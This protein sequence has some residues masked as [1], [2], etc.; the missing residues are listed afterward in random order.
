MP[1]K[2]CVVGGCRHSN[3]DGS[4]HLFPKDPTV[5]AHAQEM[6]EFCK[7][8]ATS[9][10]ASH[11][12]QHHMWQSLQRYWLPKLEP[13]QNGSSVQTNAKTQRCAKYKIPSAATTTHAADGSW[14]ARSMSVTVRKAPVSRTLP[15][16]PAVMPILALPLPSGTFEDP[17]L[18]TN[19][20]H[21]ICSL[22]NCS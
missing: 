19:V 18:S 7:L 14:R 4:V 3:V 17:S 16:P 5:C 20:C 1:V 12:C 9:L 13:V 10:R 15:V 22:I 11:C 2:F 6:G 21:V 8:H